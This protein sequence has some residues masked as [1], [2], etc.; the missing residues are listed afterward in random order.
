MLQ[1]PAYF[2]P[3]RHPERSI[4]RRW[5]VLSQMKNNGVLSPGQF[6][7]LKVRPLDMS[8]FRKVTFT[9]DKAPYL[10]ATLK[11]E[12]RVLLDSADFRRND[13]SK[14]DLYK[15]GL[16]IY[17]TIDPAYQQHAEAAAQEHLRKTQNRFFTVWR[18]RD[19]WTYRSSET[20]DEEIQNR[21]ENLWSLVR[22]GDRF[23]AAW[24][25]YME[26]V[27][28]QVKDRY[29]FEL[30][31]IDIERMLKEDKKQGTISKMVAARFVSASQ[32]SVYRRIMT[33]SEWAEIKNQYRGLSAFV[34]KKYGEK[35]KMKVFSYSGN[36]FEKDTFMSPLDSLRYHRMFLQTGILAVDPTTSEIKAWVGGANFKYFQL[37]HTQT[38]RQVGSTFKPFVYA[39]AITQQG[40]S[41]CFEVYDQAVTIPAGYQN[42]TTSA[43]WTPKDAAGHY[44]G[45]RMTLKEALK[46]SVNSV[47]AFLMKQLGDTEPVRGLINNMGI[48]SS[49]RRADGQYRV[50]RQPSICLGASDLTVMEM[51]AAYAT[52][53]NKGMYSKPYVIRKIEDKNGKVIYQSSFEEK[54][55]LPE[56][57]NYVIV[58]ML[59]YNMKGAPGINT[60][61][62]EIG[63]KTGT[64]N[65]Y[66]DGWFMGITP[67]LVVGTW[68]GGEDRWIRFLSLSDGQGAKMARPIVA[69]FI[70][71]LEKDPKSGY[72][73]NARF[74]RPANMTIEINCSTY[75]GSYQSPT[76]EEFA[77]DI[78]N[79]EVPPADATKGKKP[80]KGESF[81]DEDDN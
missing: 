57:A 50:P 1:N 78:Y 33:G 55:A 76:D 23:Q 65:N 75:A 20:T 80:T 38:Q 4:R 68:V 73:Y 24:P 58:D 32:A 28:K 18:G 14:Y 79:D 54:V 72:D 12:L 43:D 7:S 29:G 63:G 21:K 22:Q 11:Q 30:R 47:S 6:D 3:V 70:S 19:P 15:D 44:S 40:I 74:V 36:R 69:S 17:T 48:D 67:R 49:A 34:N 42:F 13:G 35:N 66:T 8:K 45:Q 27:E 71:R 64:T 53:A 39:T 77:P 46:N 60:L 52:F 59:K 37:D 2:S 5:I 26:N 81:G 51:T 9:D 61:K 41:P 62:S 16:K 31:D 10:C 25:R 56:S